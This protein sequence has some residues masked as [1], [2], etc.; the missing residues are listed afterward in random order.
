M[1]N[2]SEFRCVR[3]LVFALL[4]AILLF[5]CS[6]PESPPVTDDPGYDRSSPDNLMVMLAGSY[7]EKDLAGYDECLDEDF[8]FQFTEEVADELGLK[9]SEPWWG[10]TAD[11]MSTMDMFEHPYVQ[12]VVFSFEALED[13]EPHVEVRPDTTFSGYFRRFDPLI[14]VT[15]QIDGSED[16]VRKYRVDHSWLDVVVVPDRFTEG[17]WR[18]VRIDEVEKQPGTALGSAAAATEGSTWGGI[19]AMWH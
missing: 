9:P 11:L 14:E 17:L 15:T 6:D 4:A 3:F 18:I 1:K 10:K 12:D 8:L 19:K 2:L 13:W 16:P 7:K 5:S